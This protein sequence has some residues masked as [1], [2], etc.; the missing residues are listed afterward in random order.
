VTLTIPDRAEESIQ[1]LLST[2]RFRT[3]PDVIE[4]GLK[5]LE[6]ETNLHPVIESFPTGSLLHLFTPEQN[7]EEIALAKGSS[8]IVEDE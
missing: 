8:L 7:A 2:G 6:A 5:A 3:V 4:A 1:R